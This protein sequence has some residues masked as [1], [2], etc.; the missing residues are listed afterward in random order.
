M[1]PWPCRT[2]RS[3]I[4]LLA[5]NATSLNNNGAVYDFKGELDKALEHYEECLVME[6]V[7]L[8]AQHAGMATS[9]PFVRRLRQVTTVAAKMSIK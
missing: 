1:S 5:S 2:T 8:P 3:T 6:R 4:R 7:V 9:E